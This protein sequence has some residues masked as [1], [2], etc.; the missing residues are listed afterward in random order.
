MTKNVLVTSV[1]DRQMDRQTTQKAMTSV[2]YGTGAQ[3]RRQN[4]KA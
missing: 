4:D 3:L 2:R 1:S